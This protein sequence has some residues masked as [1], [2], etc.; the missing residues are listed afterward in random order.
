MNFNELPAENRHKKLSAETNVI[1]RLL[2]ES[3][4]DLPEDYLEFLRLN[5]GSEDSFS[6]GWIYLWPAQEVL[7]L[8]RDYEIQQWVPGFFCIGSDGGGE[9]L[10]FDTRTPHPWKIY[11]IPFGSLAESEAMLLADSFA[12]FIETLSRTDDN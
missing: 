12:A 3:E 4:L 9:G 10:C 6:D 8:N 11:K 5:K 7:Q 2:M 1:Q